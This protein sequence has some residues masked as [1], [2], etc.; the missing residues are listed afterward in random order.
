MLVPRWRRTA[1][2][3]ESLAAPIAH[4]QPSVAAA[5][6]DRFAR[7][8]AAELTIELATKAQFREAVVLAVVEQADVGK[9]QIVASA[10]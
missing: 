1:P 2:T 4:K 9:R 8:D 6:D 5:G 7:L 10:P 3:A